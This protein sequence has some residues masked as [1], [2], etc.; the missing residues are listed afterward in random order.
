MAGK[1]QSV[2]KGEDEIIWACKKKKNKGR[3]VNSELEY[4]QRLSNVLYLHFDFELFWHENAVVSLSR[5]KLIR[6]RWI[7][8]K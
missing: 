1:R 8:N 7:E 4:Q 3:E 5:R 2:S 6:A